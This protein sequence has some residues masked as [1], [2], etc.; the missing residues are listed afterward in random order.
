MCETVLIPHGNQSKIVRNVQRKMLLRAGGFFPFEPFFMRFEEEVPLDEAT[1]V[2]A[3][4]IETDG[5]GAFL[6]CA[7][8]AGQRAFPG[9]ILLGFMVECAGHSRLT[10]EDRFPELPFAFPVFKIA[11]VVFSGSGHFMR[12]RIVGERWKKIR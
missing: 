1:S 11:R 6:L 8:S 12:W 9:R 5:S 2:R 4:R 7:V 10:E 3:E